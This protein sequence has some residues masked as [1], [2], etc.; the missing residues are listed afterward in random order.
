MEQQKSTSVRIDTD[1]HEKISEIT[2]PK[3]SPKKTTIQAYI[4]TK[5]KP[6]VDRD[7]NKLIQNTK[8]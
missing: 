2:K 8:K 4:N 1:I 6:I 5:L 3:G 7:Y